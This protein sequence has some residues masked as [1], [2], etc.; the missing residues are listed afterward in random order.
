MDAF[1]TH[2]DVVDNY[3]EYLKS[4][5]KI[6]DGRINNEVEK[7]FQSDGFIPMPLV[8]FNPAFE[9]GESLSDLVASNQVHPY[10]EKAIG[11][12]KLCR[13]QIEALKIGLSNQGLLL[14]MNF[15]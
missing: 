9:R 4:F 13:H 11:N 5:I 3:R 7:A 8:Q 6:A 10:L 12:Y 2:Q 14:H 1:R 15:N